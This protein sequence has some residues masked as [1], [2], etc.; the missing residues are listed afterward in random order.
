MSEEAEVAARATQVNTLLA[1]KDKA[2]ALAAAL[3]NPPIN[4]KSE[5]VK[6]RSSLLLSMTT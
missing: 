1:K 6:V 2:G 4:S 3:N 5:E